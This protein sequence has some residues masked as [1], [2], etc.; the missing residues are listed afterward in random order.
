M[1]PVPE[2]GDGGVGTRHLDTSRPE[3]ANPLEIVGKFLRL[4]KPMGVDMRLRPS[5]EELGNSKR[6]PAATP[7]LPP[8]PCGTRPFGVD[9]GP[10]TCQRTSGRHRAWHLPA[11]YQTLIPD[12]RNT[13]RLWPNNVDKIDICFTALCSIQRDANNISTLKI[14]HFSC[15]PAVVAVEV[16]LD[17][18]CF[19]RTDYRL[20]FH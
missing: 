7:L 16:P 14:L 20:C 3:R 19:V 12:V 2:K 4:I 6:Q 10:P 5:Q 13:D 8:L 15:M 11:K 18:A 9:Q 1:T 17:S